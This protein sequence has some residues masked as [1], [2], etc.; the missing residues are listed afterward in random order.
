M[1]A[2]IIYELK[3]AAA[4]AVFYAFYRLLLSRETLH[5]LNRII[6]VSTAVLSFILPLC[7][8]TFHVN[9][10]MPQLPVAEPSADTAASEAMP[11]TTSGQ[12]LWTAIVAIYAAGALACLINTAISI[13]GVRRLIRSGETVY[14]ADGT[15]LSV[16]ERRMSPCSWMHTIILSREDYAECSREVIAHEQ[17]HID[18][19]HSNDVLLVDI[20]TAFQWFNPMMWMLRSDLRAIHEFEADNAVLSKGV[21]IKEYS[22]ILI[23]KAISESGYSVT[24]GFNHS[25]LKNRITMMSKSKSKLAKGLRAFYILPLICISLALTAEEKEDIKVNEPLVILCKQE[26]VTIGDNHKI[27]TISNGIILEGDGMSAVDMDNLARIE[28]HKTEEAVGRYKKQFN[29]DKPVNG[30][31]I[32]VEKQ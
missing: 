32:L 1:E 25:I 27:K 10:E 5:R 14:L 26:D 28:V 8:I 9:M 2:L 24:N 30:V 16:V 22:Y 23:K 15:R 4:I 18:L 11:A 7:I 17:A 13:L 31:I 21:N 19:R 3:V 29:C 20:L 6:L 12:W